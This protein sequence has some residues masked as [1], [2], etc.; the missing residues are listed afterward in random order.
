MRCPVLLHV[1]TKKGKG[2]SP[3]EDM[4]SSFH[5]VGQFDPRTGVCSKSSGKSFS[6]TFGETLCALSADDN[7]ICA[8][9]AAMEQ[10]TGLSQFAASYPSR[11][12]DVGI[13][14]GHA[15][16][17]AGGLAKQGMIPVF[18]VYSTFLQRSYDML[19]HDIALLN[20]H[21][22]FAVDRAGRVGEDGDTHHGVFDAGYLSQ[23]PGMRVLC[24]SSQEEL[25][26]MM[27]A[28]IY[29]MDGPVAVRYPKGKDG[30]YQDVVWK[31][32]FN[33]NPEC[34]IVTYGTTINLVLEAVDRL[35]TEG[36]SVDVLKLDQIQPLDLGNIEVSVQN[37]GRILV[38]EESMAQGC[39][40]DRILSGLTQ[41]GIYPACRLLN[42]GDRFIPHGDLESLRADVGLDSVGIYK[43]A[44]ELLRC[45]K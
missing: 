20:L 32:R 26:R 42:L 7:R 15:V 8:I 45:E 36:V 35:Q 37:S 31:D 33:I 38:V 11:F 34:T 25:R 21:V 2:Y 16:S 4:P 22:I 5:G 39:V 44:K 23:I 13:A 17:M 9:T 14:E 40:G 1:I 27:Q 19:L 41:R 3:A 6:E 30:V 29:D 43:K 28:A 12:F 24:P 18:A 10:G